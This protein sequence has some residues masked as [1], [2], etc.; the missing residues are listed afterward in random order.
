MRKTLATP[1]YLVLTVVVA[2]LLACNMPL[3]D[4]TGDGT[5]TATKAYTATE[6]GTTLSP[7]VPTNTST[8]TVTSIPLTDT[9]TATS[10]LIPPTSTSTLAPTP[11]NRAQ[12]VSDVN[13]PDGTEVT[14]NTNFT[15]TW[16]ITNTGSCTWTSGY[17]LIFVTGDKMGA[18]DETQLTNGTIPPGATA[19]ISIQLKAPSSAGTYQG[20]FKFKSSDNLIFGINGGAN[21][22]FWVQISA[23]G[24]VLSIPKFPNLQLIPSKTPTP[25]K[26]LVPHIIGTLHFP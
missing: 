12:Y 10:T 14:I 25:V 17:K 7:T 6:Q 4:N 23:I 15:K 11:C 18:A 26:K 8:N 2:V 13:Y 1:R 22:A 3:I 20:Y 21:D 5:A 24:Y 16:R 19:D 9:P